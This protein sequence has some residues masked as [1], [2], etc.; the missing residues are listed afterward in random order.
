MIQSK[1]W[2]TFTIGSGKEKIV[3]QVNN[4]SYNFKKKKKKIF[5]NKLF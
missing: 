3:K 2:F 5:F 4:N 1:E